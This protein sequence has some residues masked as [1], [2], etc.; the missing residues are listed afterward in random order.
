MNRVWAGCRA[1]LA[2]SLLSWG[3][4]AAARD[5][6]SGVW[7]EQYTESI[8]QV[9]QWGPACGETPRSSGRRERGILYT[10]D[11]R[12]VELVFKPASGKGFSTTACMS[13]N[14][15]LKP[16][17]RTVRD[18]LFVVQCSTSEKARSYESGRYS[19]RVVTPD[20][21]TYRET[22]RYS[23]NIEGALCVHTRRV[24]RLYVRQKNAAPPRPPGQLGSKVP[25]AKEDTRPE[26]D[27]CT[28]PGKP[29]AVRLVESRATVARGEKVCPAVDARDQNGC[30]VEAALTWGRGK[31]PRGVK[32]TIQ[33]CLKITDRAPGGTHPVRLKAAGKEL[34]FTL[35]IPRRAQV[36]RHGQPGRGERLETRPEA[37]RIDKP[38]I[39]D[40][41]GEGPDETADATGA[42]GTGAPEKPADA[43]TQ[44]GAGQADAGGED[45]SVAAATAP[46]APD[47]GRPV[48]AAGGAGAQEPA[49]GGTPGWVLPAAIGAGALLLVVVTV[50]VLRRRRGP[51]SAGGRDTGA[52]AVAGA[53]PAEGARARTTSGADGVEDGVEDAVPTEPPDDAPRPDL[54]PHVPAP[55]EDM[56]TTEPGPAPGTTDRTAGPGTPETASPAAPAGTGGDVAA[57]GRPQP[58][59]D[60]SPPASKPALTSADKPDQVF[61]TT[62]GKAVPAEARFCPYDRTP[63]YRPRSPTLQSAPVCPTCK[64]LLPVGSRFCPY[65]RT[66]LG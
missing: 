4:D 11:D 38:P 19:F 28:R 31:P 15:A 26:Q 52:G 21:I 16:K 47:A 58:P 56:M 39:P 12:G 55:T 18:K 37:G 1:L 60:A 32:L 53:G 35:E 27:P 41:A 44:G 6:M 57:G 64:R 62:C 20:R 8:V 66:R 10:V 7:K 2:A 30:P 22:T 63:I 54:T 48:A 46:T 5:D 34:V 43:G 36:A 40:T 9:D 51:R 42:P 23:R 29:V 33:G 59:P 13:A 17:E 45:A 61:C 65:D 50:L 49:A 14:P 25:G 24:R 3:A